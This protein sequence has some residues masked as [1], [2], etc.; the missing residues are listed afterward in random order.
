MKKLIACVGLPR[1]GKTSWAREQGHP[2][3]NP[4]AIRLSLT[5]Q[6][7]YPE[8]EPFVWAIAKCMV[9]SLFEAGHETVILDAT[10]TT[11]KRRFEWV[12]NE[13][14]T[15]WH[16]VDTTKSLCLERA[17]GARR[18]DLVPIIERMAEN[19]DYPGVDVDR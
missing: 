6:P 16:V 15:E 1:S 2:I 18:E 3:V 8:A 5:A 7:F 17:I 11:E 13:W 4:D 19:W 10:N 12:T 9:R 14:R